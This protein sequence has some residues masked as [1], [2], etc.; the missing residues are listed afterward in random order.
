MKKSIFLFFAAILCAMTAN[1]Y[2]QSAKDLYFDNSEAKWNSCYVYIGH[3]TWTS[4]Y[5]LTRVS[6]TQYLWKLAKADFNGGGS[7]N[8]ATGWVLCYE[9]WW[10]S[11]GESI[12][13]YV[14]H[15]DKN[16]TKKSTSAWV[17]TKIYKTNGTTSVKSDGTTKTVYAVKSYTKADYAVTINTVE[18][19]TLTVKDY[20]NNEV[21]T[22]ASKIH[23]T[24]LKF[25]ATPAS[26]Y[27]L[28][29][30]EINDG[31]NPTTIAAADLATYTHTLTSAVTITPVWRATTSTV[32][33]TATATNGTVTGGGVVEEGTSVTLSATPADGYKFVNWTVGGAEVSTANPYTFAA[34]ADV[35]VVANFEELP[36]TTVYFINT[37]EWTNV[38]AY[39]YSPANA[40]WPGVDATL[41]AEKIGGF[42]VYSYT[43]TEGKYANV[44]FNGSG[45]QTADLTW[46]D[47]KYYI[48]QYNSNTGWYTQVEAE[49][50]LV[51]PV[52]YEYVYLINTNDWTKAHIYTWNPEVAS[53][54]GAAMTKEAEQ[55]AG[56]DVYSYKVVKGTTFGGMLFNCGGDECKTG[57]QTWQAGKYYAPSKNEWY[58]DAAAAEAGLAGPVIKTYTVVGSSAPLFG[59]AWAPTETANDMAL[60][61]GTKYQLVKTDI[62]LTAATIEYKVAVNHAWEESYPGDNKNKE[63][64]ITEAG[65]YTVTFTFDS[66]TKEVNATAELTEPAVVLPT[67]GVKGAWDAWATTTTLTG[68][69]TSASAT[70]NIA[71]ADIYEFGLD[72]DGNFQASG[73]TIDK[74]NNSTVVTTNAGN[75]KLTANVLGDYTFTWTYE[76]NTLTVTYPAGEEVE[77]AKKYYIAGTLAGGWSATQQG[78]IKDGDLY[79]AI[80]SELPANT[81]QF[82]ITDGQWNTEEDKTHEFTTLGAAYAEVSIVEGNVQ[83]VTEE[84]KNITV[85]FDGS[86]I[87]FEGLTEVA[88]KCY[89]MGNGDW[90]NG[91]EMEEDGEQFKLL[92]HHIS[93]PFKFKY[94][95][96]WSDAVENYEFPGIQWVDGNITL[97]EG[98]YD[99]YYK[100]ATNNVWIEVCIPATPTLVTPSVEKGI[101]SVGE[102]KFVQFSTGN[103]QYNV[104]TN[105]W[106]F[107]T[108]QYDYVGADNINVGDPTFTGT[109]DMFGW[110]ADGKYGVNPSN[111]NEDYYGTFQDWGTLVNE[112][113]WYTLSADDWK[114]L[115]NTRANAAN[116]KQI[117]KVNNGEK[118]I[119]GIM[120]FPDA[121][122][123]PADVNVVAENDDYF[124]VNIYNYNLDQWAKLE[125]AGAIFLPAAGRRA[126]GYGNMINYDQQVETRD[127]YLVN[128]GF[129]RWQDNTNIYCYYWTSTINESTNDVSFLHNINALGNDEYTIGTGAVWGE[130]GRYGQSVRLV[131][132]ATPDYERTV[133]SG[134]YGTICLPNGGLLFGASA[135]SVAK[136]EGT[137]IL[138]DEVGTTMVGGTPYVVFPNTG[139]SNLYV[140]YTDNVEAPAGNANGLYGSYTREELAPNAGNYIMLPGN[141]YAEVTGDRVYVGKN[142][143]YFR[144]ADIFPTAPA[145]APGVRRIAIGQA[146]QVATGMENVDAS[147]QPVKTIINGQLYILRGEK[148]YDAQGKLVK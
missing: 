18:G 85:I 78:M 44:I 13:K 8:G 143:A 36:K 83:I 127:E 71:A 123:M 64:S 15:G 22:G 19:G 67:V 59:T 84:A 34:E 90:E 37:N 80:F 49:G 12:D 29:A 4:C 57:D 70:V 40:S 7:W 60:V 63:L 145:P 98:Y 133:T 95:E 137:T 16:V 6:G 96:S 146:P 121:W 35:E 61:E 106:S 51:V 56:K 42:D 81:Y 54:P 82:K 97:P 101:F 5:P 105:T 77:I 43:V 48:H 39:A 45:G 88:L 11:K 24:V 119:V 27:V 31:T 76:T 124:K 113:D 122:T 132:K 50:I 130:K 26:G 112:A 93:A 69:N 1:A 91:V 102:G 38:K 65:K 125:E 109:I 117:A 79:K 9:K 30:V 134:D 135:F 111:K 147:A 33:V 92:C 14:W 47:G 144:I 58:A 104:G 72:V 17:D 53:W 55:I 115:L 107:A 128:G 131:K 20:D 94:G 3:G 28:D 108:N 138:L 23:L 148:M 21:A 129:Y 10:D 136:M 126:G 41:E 25:S 120:L 73:A 52:E 139:A 46:T 110:S 140:F 66:N 87:T 114:Y 100:K 103:L 142:R 141:K 86:K 75:I 32:T 62:A 74:A 68:D 2:N 118:D 99:F 89:L 116:L